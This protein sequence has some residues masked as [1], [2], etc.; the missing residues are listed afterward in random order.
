MGFPALFAC[1]QS[2]FIAWRLSLAEGRVAVNAAWVY[3]PQYT[4]NGPCRPPWRTMVSSV[5]AGIKG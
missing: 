3:G 2:I 4:A 1:Q 5:I